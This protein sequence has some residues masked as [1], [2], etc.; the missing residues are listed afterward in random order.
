M[1]ALQYIAEVGGRMPAS[2]RGMVAKATASLKDGDRVGLS[3]V[4]AP[5]F[6]ETMPVDEK[7]EAIVQWYAGLPNDYQDF[8]TLLNYSRLLACYK[9]HLAA[10]VGNL[11]GQRN[12]CEFMRKSRY[13]AKLR[14][15]MARDNGGKPP[16]HAAAKTEVD[17]DEDIIS[18]QNEEQ[19]SD[20]AHQS[21]RLILQH[22]ED[23]LASMRQQ[24]ATLRKEEWA[25]R[26]G[27]GTQN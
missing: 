6:A 25:E 7:I 24:I 27:V 14:E 26:R 9:V 12:A 17:A 20:A 13:A 1:L 15:V 11:A 4:L 23:V 3:M 22:S 21:A 19:I 18:L 2:A 10:L 8:N 5:P 16:S